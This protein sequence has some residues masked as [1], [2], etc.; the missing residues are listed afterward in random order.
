MRAHRRPRRSAN[1]AADKAPKKVPAERMET[2]VDDW[3]E[4]ISNW[5]FSS[6]W[7]VENSFNQYLTSLLAR[8]PEAKIEGAPTYLIAI[9]P[10]IVPVS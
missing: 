6:L 1:G 2:M 5:P 4:V 7:P 3:V 10:E 8:A 9:I